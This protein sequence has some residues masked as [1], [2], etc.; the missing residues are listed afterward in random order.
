MA[1]SSTP[2][3]PAGDLPPDDDSAAAEEGGCEGFVDQYLSLLS[4]YRLECECKANPDRGYYFHTGGMCRDSCKWCRNG[5]CALTWTTR[6]FSK[7][8]RGGDRAVAL[9]Q[10]RRG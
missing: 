10:V 2:S 8:G 9:G 4:N 5:A 7:G 1:S 3:L 6:L